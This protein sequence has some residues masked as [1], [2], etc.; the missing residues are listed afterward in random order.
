MDKKEIQV[1]TMLAEKLSYVS[2]Y[3]ELAGVIDKALSQLD[4]D[5]TDGLKAAFFRL[6]D[7]MLGVDKQNRDALRSRRIACL[8]EEEKQEFKKVEEIIDGNLLKYH[9]QPIV[10]ALNG[11]VFSY[12]ALMRSA[13]DPNITPFHIL[14]YAALNDR[15]EDIERATFINVLGLIGKMREELGGRAVF[16]NSIPDVRLGDADVEKIS[17]L[18]RKYSDCTVV[19]LTESAEADEGQLTVLKDRYGSLNVKIAVDDYGTGYSNISNLL[20]YTPNFVKIDRSLLSKIN[21]DAKKRHFV[22]DIIEFCHDNNILALAEGVENSMELKTVILMGVDLIQ[23]FYTARPS[24]EIVTEIPYEIKQEIR[25]FQQQRIDGKETH[26][27]KVDGSERILLEKLQ[28]YGYKCLRIMPGEN[29]SDITLVGE[30]SLDSDVNIEIDNGFKGRLTLENAHLANSKNRPCICL[31]DNCRVEL[32]VFGDCKLEKGG[33]L[34][35]ESSELTFTG[36]GALEINVN[37]SNYYGIGGHNDMR[38]GRISFGADVEYHINAYGEKG[39]CIGSGLG[40][41]IDIHRGVFSFDVNGN[42]G[43]VIGALSGPAD[44]DIRNCGIDINVTIAKGVLIGSCDGDAE[45]RMHGMSFKT[46]AGGKEIACVGSLI[47]E[48]NIE[49]YNSNFVSDVRSDKMTVLGSLW[50]SSKVD[51]RNLS[52]NLTAAGDKAYAFGGLNGCTELSVDSADMQIKLNSKLERI[53]SAKCESLKLG[54]G[55]YRVTF[56]DK[57]IMVTPNI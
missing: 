40:G 3:E 17:E 22:R 6:G 19:E 15:L 35:P 11:E 43:V 39:T 32:S 42:N 10:S 54:D 46:V 1:M 36:L 31:G 8:T 13:G 2:T 41:E 52:M 38:H 37:T 49:L 9:F 20:R 50:G 56:N 53:T 16:I 14:K 25:R 7:R 18:L 12:E 26:V 33:I 29:V 4:C 34:V 51:M 5:E 21:V 30:S 55:R 27:Y 47:G 57:E 23:G 28:K 44:L 24:P 45:L 48:A